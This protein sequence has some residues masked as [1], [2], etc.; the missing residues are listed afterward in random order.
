MFSVSLYQNYKCLK[1]K[2]KHY[3][4]RNSLLQSGITN[5]LIR[6][7]FLLHC[8]S[9]PHEVIYFVGCFV[10]GT[11]EVQ[12]EFDAEEILYMDFLRNEIVYTVPRFL[13]PDPSQILFGMSTLR[14]AHENKG[15]CL[16]LTAMAAHE[17]KNL[18]EEIGKLIY[19]YYMYLSTD[20]ID[21]LLMTFF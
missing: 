13:D 7:L 8:V 11:A 15:L 19:Y 2:H 20:V 5:S 3:L 14:D 9:A 6:S 16:S 4:E 10:N 17:K 1:K 18:P 21:T 12:F